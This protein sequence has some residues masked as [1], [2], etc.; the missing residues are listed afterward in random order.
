MVEAILTLPK[1]THVAIIHTAA[2]DPLQREW[3]GL[4]SWKS[5]DMPSFYNE[6]PTMMALTSTKHAIKK[7]GEGM[8]QLQYISLWDWGHIRGRK[9]AEGWEVSFIFDDKSAWP[10]TLEQF[11]RCP[12]LHFEPKC[13]W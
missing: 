3:P 11:P 5:W 1:L 13:G 9:T 8:P 12:V 7:L 6:I 4:I 10:W 2:P